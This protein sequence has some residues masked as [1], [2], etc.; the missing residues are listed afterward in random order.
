[1][2]FP[3]GDGSRYDF[4]TNWYV[5][6][7]YGELVDGSWYHEG[8]DIN[9]KTGGDT[10]DGYPLYAMA[11]G[12]IVYYHRYTHST[13]G[14]GRHLIY[15]TDDPVRWIH[16][17]HCQDVDF[18]N[19]AVDIREGQMIARIGKSGTL[20]AHLHLA[21]YTKDPSPNIDRWAR[22]V[23]ELN[24]WW[25]D[26]IPFIEQWMSPLPSPAI[27]DT[28]RIPQIGNLQVQEIRNKLLQIK[29][30]SNF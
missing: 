15:R 28:T 14:Y 10:D 6:R 24:E 30:I 7:G 1:M 20:L 13:S 21:I 9:L 22:T 8:V 26:P 18:L 23:S 2:R 29:D 11:N 19:S 4:Y 27:T 12:R 17:A 5:A 25:E 16:Y 3:V